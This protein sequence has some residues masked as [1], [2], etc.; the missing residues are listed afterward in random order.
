MNPTLLIPIF[1]H[2][3]EIGD[4][5]S[6]LKPFDLPCLIVDDGSGAPTRAV[7]ERIAAENPQVTLHRR[8]RNGGRG[9]ALKTGYRA[10]F[11]AEIAGEAAVAEPPGT[12]GEVGGTW[13]LSPDGEVVAYTAGDPETP[14]RL[15]AQPLGGKPR[16]LAAP[17]RD[18]TE[19][20]AIATA[21][22]ASFT[23]PGGELIKT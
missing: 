4:V 1:D 20:F 21:T 15:W 13:A 14:R 7:L 16:E 23:G 6:S 18:L 5:V 2:G 17:N 11:A 19:R 3:D 22:D 12:A 8:E 10:A 9:A